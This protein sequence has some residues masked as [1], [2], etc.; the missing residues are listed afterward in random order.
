MRQFC[1]GRGSGCT[2]VETNIRRQIPG[3]EYPEK[4]TELQASEASIYPDHSPVFVV[5]DTPVENPRIGHFPLP[6]RWL[7]TNAVWTPAAHLSNTWPSVPVVN[8]PTERPATLFSHDHYS[9]KV[10]FSCLMWRW[11]RLWRAAAILL[12]LAA[13]MVTTTITARRHTPK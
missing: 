10:C 2:V 13:M 5:C 4:R 1:F 11:R 12:Q 3:D 8:L 6:P 9:Y 7:K